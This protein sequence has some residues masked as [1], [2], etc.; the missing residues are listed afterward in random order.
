MKVKPDTVTFCSLIV[1]PVSPSTT[2]IVA[3]ASPES[4][5]PDVPTVIAS[6][7]VPARTFM[8]PSAAA[9]LTAA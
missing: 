6:S 7:Y 8:V 4:V 2:E 9:L 5:K 3:P 1:M